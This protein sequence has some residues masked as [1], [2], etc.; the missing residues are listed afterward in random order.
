MSCDTG[1]VFTAD[2]RAYIAAALEAVMTDTG[3]IT[4][5][6]GDGTLDTGTGGYTPDAGTTIYTG[7]M[8]IAVGT[9]AVVEELFGVDAV[10]TVR[11]IGRFPTGTPVARDDRV[12]VTS[13]SD[14]LIGI[15]SFR[16]AVVLVG[17]NHVQRVVG[18]ELLE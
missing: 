15:R 13:G 18:L 8:S 2:D 10:G 4:R 17:T 5:G 7:A 6:A 12:K 16:V 9:N 3:T 14:P 11:Y 1:A